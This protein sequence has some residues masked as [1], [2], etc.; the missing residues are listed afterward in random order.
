MNSVVAALMAVF[1]QGYASKLEPLLDM[2][3]VRW[4]R[5]TAHSTRQLF[6]GCKVFSFSIG[7][8]VIHAA[9]IALRNTAALNS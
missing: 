9:F 5:R 8:P 4:A 3:G 2:V 7:K 1:T 6:N